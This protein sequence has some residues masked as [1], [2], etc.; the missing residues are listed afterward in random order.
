M[1]LPGHQ[2]S[3]GLQHK[4]PFV[5]SGVG[6]L[7]VVLL[8]HL[9]SIKN[10]VEIDLPRGIPKRG[11][12]AERFFNF[13]ESIFQFLGRKRRL[14]LPNCVEIFP[15]R[16]ASNRVGL[17]NRGSSEKL[18]LGKPFNPRS[19]FLQVSGPVSQIGSHAE[20]DFLRL[21]FQFP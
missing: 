21:E 6:N 3:E 5:K 4:T 13:F 1:D 18:R 8:H 19:R 20:I 15:L 2:F 17:E 7:K 11:F 9:I 12:S 14:N 16:R 10:D